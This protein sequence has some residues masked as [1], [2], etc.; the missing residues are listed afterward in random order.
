MEEDR[1][2]TA[3]IGSTHILALCINCEP[4]AP[5]HIE[6]VTTS[7]A[8]I[9]HFLKKT[10][11]LPKADG[12]PQPSVVTALWSYVLANRRKQREKLVVLLLPIGKQR[13][14][15]LQTAQASLNGIIQTHFRQAP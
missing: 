5:I 12:R 8:V 14:K 11:A 2:G 13:P 7:G 6:R 10:S 3:F 1:W 4:N 15:T 9:A